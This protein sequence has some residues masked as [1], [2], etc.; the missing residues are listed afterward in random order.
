[1]VR[2][3]A[4]KVEDEGFGSISG[5]RARTGIGIDSRGNL[6]IVVV[7]GGISNYSYGMTLSE[8]AEEMRNRGAVD[9]INLDGGTSST[10]Y[11]NG[12]IRNYPG[13]GT[14]ERA[15]CSSVLF[16]PE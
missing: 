12:S 2:D 8:L 10:I 4:A 9:A 15:V 6:L 11:F 14:G 1:L 7:D 16:V 5:K 13:Q 3:G